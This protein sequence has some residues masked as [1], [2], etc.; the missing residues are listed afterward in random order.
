MVVNAGPPQGWTGSGWPVAGALLRGQVI[1][2]CRLQRERIPSS[3]SLAAEPSGTLPGLGG[4]PFLPAL[5][6][7][8]APTPR[9]SVVH[10][11]LPAG[12]PPEGSLSPG[13]S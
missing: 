1:G 7:L 5:C 10:S 12:A 8:G 6:G 13:A 4:S 3:S 2:Q 11:L 9:F